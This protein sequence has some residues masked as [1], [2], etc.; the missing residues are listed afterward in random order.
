MTRL[1]FF[2]TLFCAGSLAFGAPGAHGPGGEH[3]DAPA[4]AQAGSTSAAPRIETFTETFELVGH[5]YESELSILID[6]YATN[7]PVLNGKLEVQF[8]DLKAAGQFHAGHGDYSITDERLLKA[9]R[10]PGKH[11]LVF[12]V[13]A[14]K[15]SDLMEG[16][17]NVGDADAAHEHGH[18]HW[19]AWAVGAAVLMMLFAAVVW[20]RRRSLRLGKV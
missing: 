17:L 10:K 5:L 14:D 20:L 4:G 9:L 18:S 19:W 7:E 3:L 11:V 13:F 2:L 1:I 16:T 6:R 15:D 8:N 12:T